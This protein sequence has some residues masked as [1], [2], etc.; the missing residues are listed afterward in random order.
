MTTEV[1]EETKVEEPKTTTPDLIQDKLNEIESKLNGTA[2]AVKVEEKVAEKAPEESQQDATATLSDQ[3]TQAL[4][5]YGFDPDEIAALGDRGTKFADKVVKFQSETGRRFSE[6]GRM[7]RELKT[8]RETAKTETS[9]PEESSADDELVLELGETAAKKFKSLEAEIKS[10]REKETQEATERM[11]SDVESF[12]KALDGK[13]YPELGTIPYRQ[14]PEDSPQATEIEELASD[15]GALIQAKQSRGGHMELKEALQI[16]LI[17][18]YGD[19]KVTTKTTEKT[20]RHKSLTTRATHAEHTTPKS[21]KDRAMDALSQ[22][23][24]KTGI[25]LG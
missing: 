16:A 25:A 12:I 23:E 13:S 21:S 15:A 11:T 6:I 7:E 4:T 24:E 9:K 10:L 18:R 17:A 5:K 20:D 22:W 8:L 3:H 2:D 19:R 1:A 14:L